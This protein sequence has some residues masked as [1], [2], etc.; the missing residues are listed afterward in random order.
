MFLYA[1]KICQLENFRD[2][3]LSEGHCDLLGTSI[4]S[5]SEDLLGGKYLEVSGRR[6]LQSVP[7]K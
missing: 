5:S 3:S 6:E 7:Q 4:I 1:V 2:P